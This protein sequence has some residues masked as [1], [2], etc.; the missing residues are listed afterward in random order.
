MSIKLLKIYLIFDNCL[1]TTKKPQLMKF[2]IFLSKVFFQKKFRVVR[3]NVVTL[4][5]DFCITLFDTK[6]S[7]Q[8]WCTGFGPCG[9]QIF[10]CDDMSQNGA[11]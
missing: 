2:D 1:H 8:L 9:G 6:D 10:Y 7:I 3:R 11:I 4:H 5:C